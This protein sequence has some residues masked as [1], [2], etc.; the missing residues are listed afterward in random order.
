MVA[1][2]L[3]HGLIEKTDGV[4]NKELMKLVRGHMRTGAEIDI[5]EA[6]RIANKDDRIAERAKRGPNVDKHVASIQARTGPLAPAPTK[7][8][9]KAAADDFFGSR[10]WQKLRYQAIKKHGGL[11]QCCGAG[12]KQGKVIH[13]D[14]IK[15][16]SK[17]PEFE[18]DLNNLQIL[19]EDCNMGKGA[20]DQTD[21]RDKQ[22]RVIWD[23][24]PTTH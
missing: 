20:W 21:W 3:R 11:C 24:E 18:W 23:D 15:P 9:K 13:V 1:Y 8:Q 22:P 12:R 6:L 17:F 19:C 10:E 7:R 16:R 14:H 2:S 5:R 4:K